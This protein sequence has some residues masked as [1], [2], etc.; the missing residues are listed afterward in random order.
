MRR[1]GFTLAVAIG[2]AAIGNT[3][4]ADAPAF[5]FTSID[6]PTATATGAFGINARGEVVGFYRD[7]SNRQHGYVWGRDGFRSIDYPGAIFTDARGISPSGE[8]VGTYRNPGEPPVNF[9]GYRLTPDGE[10]LRVDYPGHTSTIAQRIGP[11]GTI[12]GCYHDQDQMHTMFGMT[13]S[14]EAHGAL[15]MSMTMNNGA[16]PDGR[17]MVGL[18]TDMDAGRG[19]AYLVRDGEFIGFDVPG[20]AFT[21]GWDI[22]A[23]REAVGVYQDASGRF[24]GF[25]VDAEWNFTTLD[26]PGAAATRAFGINARGDVVGTYIDTSNRT[27]GFLARRI[28]MEP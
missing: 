18:Y 13:I 7:A 26:Y 12:Y 9:H 3:A 1:Y 23:G 19:R 15:D 8:I 28:D 14:G 6:V 10:Y 5:V 20:S 22:N 24:H 11:D 4:G 27:H 17:T 25:I 2:L 21:A 16:T